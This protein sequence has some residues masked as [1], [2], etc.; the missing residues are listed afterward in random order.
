MNLKAFLAAVRRFWLTFVLV[1]AVLMCAG[2]VWLIRTPAQYVSTSQLMVTINGSTT[3]AAY[4]N[5]NVVTGRIA[6]YIA[7][8]TSD[9]ICQRV[10]DRLGL[11][12]TSAELATRINA[13]NVPPKTSII[14]VAVTDASPT[15]AREIADTVAT[16][17]VSYSAAIESPTGED[18]GTVQTTIVSPAGEPASDGRKKLI[19]GGLGAVAA[20]LLASCT[21]SNSRAIASA[22]FIHRCGEERTRSA[23]ST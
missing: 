18:G 3:A 13:I 23:L 12:M 6:T 14:D 15:R 2:A 4:Q 17:F 11:P 5:D 8:L 9:V 10:V 16:E 19:L 1:L 7:L 21:S 20:L 22:S